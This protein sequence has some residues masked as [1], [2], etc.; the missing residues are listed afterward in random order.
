LYSSNE[1]ERYP[2]SEEEK[3]E[4]V[5]GVEGKERSMAYCMKKEKASS[6]SK[7]PRQ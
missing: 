6:V 3:E 1:E 5:G 7:A 4:N 2:E